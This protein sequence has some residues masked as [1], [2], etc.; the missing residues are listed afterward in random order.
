ML[1]YQAVG[2]SLSGTWQGP[3]APPANPVQAVQCTVVWQ[4]TGSTLTGSLTAQANGTTDNYTLQGRVQG[5]QAAGT[6]T[7]PAD[8]SVFQFEAAIQN[9]Q[10]LLAIGQTGKVLMSGQLVRS[11]AKSGQAV[12]TAP[13]PATAAKPD[14]LYRDPALVGTWQTTSNYG[15]GLTDG[16]FYGSTSSAM[17]LNADG[18]FGDGGSSG[19][20][21]G[22]GV[23]VQSSGGS[24]PNS[25]IAKLNAMGARW[26]TKGNV[27]YVRVRVN[28]QQQDVPT[29]K[30]YVENG[31]MLL[32]DQKTGQKTLYTRR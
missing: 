17:I 24:N 27:I 25:A 28:G 20:A 32:T 12:A 1:T 13:R 11:T 21:S 7:Y 18:S 19:Y 16:G 15:G 14:G 5:S 30:Y 23:S 10:L 9:G 4:V 8:G 2:Q 26:Y 22:S 6:A 31:R 29:S 3:M